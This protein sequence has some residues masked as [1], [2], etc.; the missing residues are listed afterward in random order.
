MPCVWGYLINTSPYVVRTKIRRTGNQ[1]QQS[2]TNI[3][4]VDDEENVLLS[5][6]SYLSSE[7]YTVKIFTALVKSKCE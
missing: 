6:A 1:K 4:I 2:E 3:L 7:G 5:F